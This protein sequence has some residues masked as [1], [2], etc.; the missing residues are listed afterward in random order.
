MEQE[1]KTN[2]SKILIKVVATNSQKTQWK[3]LVNIKH[4]T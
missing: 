2:I 3:I 1:I 4:D